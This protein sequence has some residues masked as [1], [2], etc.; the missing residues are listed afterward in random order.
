MKLV[1]QTYGIQ[2]K[3]KICEKIDTK[4]RRRAQEQDR[5]HRWAREGNRYG[6]SIE[7]AQQAIAA[8]DTEIYE[9]ECERQKRSQAIC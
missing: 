7:K 6:A 5:L 4:R 8:L 9:L 2:Q 3:C 1:M